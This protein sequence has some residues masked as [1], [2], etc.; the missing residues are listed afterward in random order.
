MTGSQEKKLVRNC[1]AGK[2]DAFKKLYDHFS[3]DMYKVCLMYAPDADCANDF[4][5]EGFM[6]VFQNLHK[7]RTPGSLGGWM[8][9]VIVNNCIDLI[10]R[11]HWP[12]N[13]ASIDHFTSNEEYTVLE[14][15]F[16]RE[17]NSESF[18]DILQHLPIG[19]RTIL[20][21]YYLEEYKHKEISEQMGISVGT[22]KSQL[23][24]A[25]NYLKKTLQD[26]L[27]AEELEFYVGKLD[28]KVV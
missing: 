2:K 26:S 11:D 7:Y 22:S 15:E 18:F 21:L 20:N 27:S 28:K 6:K 4:L 14:N 1:I 8:R 10:R 23:W 5:Q 9:R 16:E 13:M 24:K 17:L 3:E 19:Y 25:K 12:K